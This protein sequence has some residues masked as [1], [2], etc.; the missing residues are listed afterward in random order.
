MGNNAAC[1]VLS[2][3]EGEGWGQR[4]R[5][6]KLGK[7]LDL[8]SHA[9]LNRAR[10]NLKLWIF[11]NSPAEGVCSVLDWSGIWTTRGREMGY[12]KQSSTQTLSWGTGQGLWGQASGL[13]S[14][15][16]S[17]SYRGPGVC[18]LIQAQDPLCFLKQLQTESSLPVVEEGIQQPPPDFLKFFYLPDF[19]N[20]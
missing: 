2:T 8:L 16:A 14:A 15:V 4:E 18:S 10:S 13:L 11:E 12:R 6:S 20:V 7:G 3:H 5:I 1:Q 17:E 9:S 19:L